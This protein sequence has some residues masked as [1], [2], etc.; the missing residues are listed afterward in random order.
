VP[1]ATFILSENGNF[2]ITLFCAASN[3]QTAMETCQVL[4]PF[5]RQKITNTNHH[6]V[7]FPSSEVEG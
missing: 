1:S 2:Q 5:F 6:L 3:R 7:G 4:K